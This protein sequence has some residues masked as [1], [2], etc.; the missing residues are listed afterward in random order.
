MKRRVYNLVPPSRTEQCDY[1]LNKRGVVQYVPFAASSPVPLL[2][3]LKK[4]AGKC[5]HTNRLFIFQN[6]FSLLSSSSIKHKSRQYSSCLSVMY[7]NQGGIMYKNVHKNSLHY[8]N[9]A[10]FVLNFGCIRRWEIACGAK[11]SPVSECGVGGRN[12]AA[13]CG[14]DDH[15][16]DCLQV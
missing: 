6:R 2:T 14:Q 7:T 13:N 1:S 4:P 11:W 15:H 8:N 16:K 5:D 10:G 12:A 9:K 3:L